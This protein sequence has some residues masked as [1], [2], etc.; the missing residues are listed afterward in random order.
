M[1][2][3]LSFLCP[4]GATV[5]WTVCVCVCVCVCARARAYLNVYRLYMNYRRYQI[6]LQ[7]N[8]F[9]QILSLRRSV[10]WIF[11]FR[12][13]VWRLMGWYVT[14]GRTFY[15]LLFKQKVVAAQLLTR[16]TSCHSSKRPLFKI[17]FVST[18]ELQPT[19]RGPG[20]PHY[21]GFT[22]TL[23]HTT[24]GRTSL[25]E[26]SARRRDLYLTTHVTHNRQTSVPPAGFEHAIP[27]SERP[28]TPRLRPRGRC[29]RHQK[30]YTVLMCGWP[31]IVIQCG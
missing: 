17:L 1:S 7:W 30:Y 20:P 9:T 13:P 6:T 14:L 10:D 15:C 8:I 29:N 5:P 16:F 3:F 19:P 22:I 23:R 2:Q 4:T 21:R 31:C 25:D 24:L 26:W 27:E 12:A 11:I 18:M 28:N